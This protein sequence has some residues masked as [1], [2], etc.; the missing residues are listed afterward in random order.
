MGKKS[1]LDDWLEEEMRDPEFRE[2]WEQTS[3]QVSF[4][5]ALG[6]MREQRGMTQQQ[7]ADATGIQRS[8]IARLENGD[9]AP[10][11]TTQTKLAH[12]LNARIEVHAEGWIDF[13]PARAR[14]K[15]AGK[16]RVQKKATA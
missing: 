3:P 12:A 7:L 4:G 16:A 5:L 6:Y 10:T 11:L 15:T 1:A 9:H 14:R 13:V 2:R 8:V